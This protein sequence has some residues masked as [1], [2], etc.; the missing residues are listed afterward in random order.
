MTGLAFIGGIDVIDRFAVTADTSTDHLIVIHT[1]TGHR[2]PECRTFLMTRL[3]LIGGINM[4]ARFTVTTGTAAQYLG[5]IDT[6]GQ[7]RRPTRRKF[8]MTKLALIRT[9]DMYT[10]CF[11]AGIAAIMAAD[12]VTDETAVVHGHGNPLR[13][14]VTHIAFIAGS[15]MTGAFALR[16]HIVMTG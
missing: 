4:I 14:A 3:T 7:H 8:V 1:G 15:E 6:Y 2:R 13:S 5:V 10:R 9:G 11:A 12:T 16:N